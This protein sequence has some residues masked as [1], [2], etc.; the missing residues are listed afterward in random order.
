MYLI[1]VSVI[2]MYR[3]PKGRKARRILDIL[4]EE[5]DWCFMDI[6]TAMRDMKMFA[7]AVAES[8]N[9]R[10]CIWQQKILR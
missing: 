10:C 7:R 5:D 4:D 9:E 6:L 3:Q 8:L 1:S 2:Q